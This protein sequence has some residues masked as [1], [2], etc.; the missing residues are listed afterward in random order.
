ME[1]ENQIVNGIT[2]N[3]IIKRNNKKNNL[4]FNFLFI[5]LYLRL[6]YFAIAKILSA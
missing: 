6:L 3:Q 5:S 4:D 1:D 2:K